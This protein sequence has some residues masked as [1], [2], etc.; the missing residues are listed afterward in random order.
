MVGQLVGLTKFL[1]LMDGGGFRDLLLNGAFLVMFLTI[2]LLFPSMIIN[3]GSLN[4]LSLIIIGCR[5]LIFPRWSF[6]LGQLPQFKGGRLL[7][8]SKSSNPLKPSL[9]VRIRKSMAIWV[10]KL[11][12]LDRWLRGWILCQ[13][14]E[15]FPVRK[16]NPIPSLFLTFEFFLRLKTL[17]WV[18]ELS[19]SGLR[20]VTPTHALFM[21]LLKVEVKETRS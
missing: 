8:Y 11:I 7:S 12:F 1:C 20:R 21:H 15:L 19:R 13:I 4:C 5:I 2:S 14:L 16:W 9:K 17:Y 10:S 3:F 6:H 18:K